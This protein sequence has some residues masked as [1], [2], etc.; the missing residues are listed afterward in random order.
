MV[1]TVLWWYR[2]CYDGTDSCAIV[3][4]IRRYSHYR[5]SYL[6][7]CIS[8]ESYIKPQR[9]IQAIIPSALYIFW[10]LHQTTTNSLQNPDNV[11]LYIFWILHQTTTPYSLHNDDRP[12]YIFWILHQ[13]TTQ[14][15]PQKKNSR[16]ISFE[17]YIKP[18]HIE[19]VNNGG[20]RCISFESYIKPQPGL[21]ADMIDE[22][23]YLLNP[24]SNHNW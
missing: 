7:R 16:C 4:P 14:T 20:T 1:P 21:P 8:F 11:K 2:Q 19:F 12:L 22:V 6:Q 3:V 5:L 9:I 18:Q 15:E 23:V 24:T 10:I 17:S 13:T